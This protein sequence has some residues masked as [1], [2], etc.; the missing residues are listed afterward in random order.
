MIWDMNYLDASLVTEKNLEDKEFSL[1]NKIE[2]FAQV[3]KGNPTD[4]LFAKSLD[5]ESK[6]SLNQ[7]QMIGLQ[8]K[9]KMGFSSPAITENFKSQFF[10]SFDFE[11]KVRAGSALISRMELKEKGDLYFFEKKG[12][13]WFERQFSPIPFFQG[14]RAL[15]G[16][17]SYWILQFQGNN[18]ES[19]EYSSFIQKWIKEKQSLNENIL[20]IAGNIE[21]VEGFKKV[22]DLPLQ[23]NSNLNI[24]EV[25]EI[26][27]K[28][29]KASPLWVRLSF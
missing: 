23:I 25:K 5:F 9:T 7:D 19:Q 12:S 6:R 21:V 15:V 4:I 8:W 10:P 22:E 3:I 26:K 1:Y 27:V 18:T 28:I 13:N 24:E 14:V 16:E 17:D 11:N 29:S 20:V 2:E